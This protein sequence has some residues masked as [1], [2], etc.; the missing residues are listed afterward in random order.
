MKLD[1][2]TRAYIECMLWT[3]HDPDTGQP[4]ER[5][6]GPADLAS[7]ALERVKADCAAFRERAGA[8]VR[9]DNLTLRGRMSAEERAGHDFWLTRNGH[10]AGFWDGDWVEP[11]ASRL[12]ALA[13][14][15]GECGLYPG[16]D[17]KIYL[18]Q[19]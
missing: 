19:G 11:V 3:S 14:S 16:D 5:D 18:F 1:Q 8:D 12:S 6:Y 4:L 10:G 7:E 9:D 17:G 2:F 15:F 13:E